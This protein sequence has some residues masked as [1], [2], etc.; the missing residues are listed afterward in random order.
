MLPETYVST[1]TKGTTIIVTYNAT[2]NKDA[3]IDGDG[4]TNEVTL[5]Y[6]NHQNT[7]PSK[8]TT[9]STSSTW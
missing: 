1:L 8:V 3:V 2:L 7:V 4:N 5:G 9:K 6:G